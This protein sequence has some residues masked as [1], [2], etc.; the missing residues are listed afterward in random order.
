M[1]YIARLFAVRVVVVLLV[2]IAL[3][4]AMD[5][6]GES[7]KILAAAG[8]GDGDL[9]R[10]ASLR[11]PVL[12]SQFLPFTVL[13]A[14]LITFSTLAATSQVVAMGTLGLSPHQTLAPVL[15]VGALCGIFH[16]AWNEAVAMPAAR[17]LSVW[18]ASGYGTG[19]PVSGLRGEITWIT[20][21]DGVMR[22]RIS[23]EDGGLALEDVAI[24]QT[25]A[26]GELS[27][28]TL[29]TGGFLGNDGVGDL[30]EAR[31]I[32]LATKA[33]HAAAFADWKPGITPA[34]LLYRQPVPEET[35]FP[36]LWRAIRVASMIGRD[37]RT[38]WAEFNHKLARPFAS[39]LMP[40]IATLAAFGLARTNTVLTRAAAALAI[41]FAYFIFD[42][43]LMSM[44]RAGALPSSIAAWGAA[45]LFLI[46]GEALLLRSEQHSL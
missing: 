34:H 28:V 32:D 17:H 2:I 12:V 43:S 8:A 25:A 45:L 13:I 40:L 24:F 15:A 6:V 36:E 27:E 33:L 1:R 18:Q 42:N 3:L 14:A 22:A 9:W 23:L 35:A 20:V 37:T 10:Y 11:F 21:R 39:V 44:A 38:L 7:T 19:R 29:A 46:A 31:T 4:Q 16:F 41:G 26:T 30:R 5:L